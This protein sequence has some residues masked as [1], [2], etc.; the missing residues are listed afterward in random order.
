MLLMAALLFA[1]TS[2]AA[3]D[4]V[5]AESKGAPPVAI[6]RPITEDHF[7]TMVTDRYRYM[8][9]MDAETVAWMKA[10]GDWSRRV[11]ASIKPKAAFETKMSA[12]GAGFGLVGEIAQAGGK[13]FYTERTPGQ[14]VFS[15]KVLEGAASRTLIDM[16]ALIKTH[17]GTP[18]A[19]DWIKP[20]RDGTKIAAGISAGGSEDSRM[21]VLD[22][23]TGKTIAGP[24][25]RAQLGNVDW[26]DDGQSLTFI[27]LRKMTPGMDA[28]E[29]Y[30]NLTAD[31]WDLRSEPK[32]LL[33]P[34]IAGAPI[35]DP[36]DGGQIAHVPHSDFVLL[37]GFTGVQ[38]EFRL[39]WGKQADLAASK[40]RWTPLLGYDA[41]VTKVDMNATTL[42]L[43]SHKDA[44]RFKVMAV[45]IGASLDQARTVI[46]ASPNRL[47]E[48]MAVAKDGLYVGVREGLYSKVL[49][50]ANDGKVEELPLPVH[51]SIGDL[52]TD[53]DTP[54]V[55]VSLSSWTT[56]PAHWRYD[57]ATRRFA[58]MKID[59][60]PPI[61]A[62]RYA[63]TDLSATARDG[64]RIPVTVLGPSGPI[65]PRP[66]LLNAYGSY[67]A[68][69]WPYF[70]TRT[71]PYIDGG[72][73]R[74]ECAVRG[75][76]EFGEAWRLAGKGNMK[77]NTWRDAIA[78]AEELIARG[79]T[80][81]AM[82]SI[83]GTSAGG[84]MVGRAVTE[85][86]DLFAGAVDR[87]GDV[88]TLRSEFMA[89]GPGNVPEFGTIKDRQGF[90][91]LYE[92]DTIQHVKPGI[93]YPAFLITAG[94]NDPRVEAWTGAK[95][96]ASLQEYPTHAPVL[97]RLEEQ[98][99]HGMGT[100]KSTR[101]AE[102]ADIAAFVLWRA[103]VPQWQ[104][105]Q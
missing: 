81:P 74:A 24:V 94:L 50:V 84:I 97:Y 32:S 22:T 3:H 59:S 15:L 80:T 83:T 28:A 12:F 52:M 101:D 13:L 44:P 38:N 105:V 35:T 100:T 55:I 72:I 23:A 68:A 85:R 93:R 64:T 75:G 26:A 104:P 39:W 16:A 8:E 71:L 92:M 21:T 79:Y 91:D 95:L 56:P 76:G 48:T 98:A 41:G 70:S 65:R 43:L 20:S 25:D 47:I 54:G 1:S 11:L 57:P 89:S 62:G 45:P 7:G 4:T 17:G 63:A 78:C 42:F 90:K 46:P 10:Q 103:G 77:P 18:H 30:R 58:D 66:M 67:G 40:S 29:K 86:P 33:G 60:H 36:D 27:R 96:A 49:H 31:T 69:G 37:T 87:V 34:T 5:P 51:G 53:V 9:K 73:S 14:E 102:E 6:P 99:G 2:N 19:I 61:D 88:N 82:L